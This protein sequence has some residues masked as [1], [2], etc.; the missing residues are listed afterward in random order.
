M[1]QPIRGSC[2]AM[3]L[4][5]R[6]GWAFGAPGARVAYGVLKLP[7]PGLHMGEFG[8][9]FAQ[10]MCDLLAV[11]NP[12]RIVIEKPFYSAKG[13]AVTIESLLGLNML[14]QTMAAT[15]GLPCEKLSAQTVRAQMLG[16]AH[17]SKDPGGTEAA[18]T[19]WALA[20]GYRPQDHN[21]ADALLLLHYAMRHGGL[22]AA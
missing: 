10:G 15:H 17:F 20:E 18:V 16:R 6:S 11:H 7:P 1:I 14:A 9:A 22:I 5:S 2:L 8:S 19:R 4:G 3:D 12:A 13:Q 21:A